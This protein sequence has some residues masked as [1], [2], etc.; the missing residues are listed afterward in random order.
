MKPY[1]I[2]SARL[3]FFGVVD[4]CMVCTAALLNNVKVIFTPPFKSIYNTQY[5]YYIHVYNNQ[6][7]QCSKTKIKLIQI[8]FHVRFYL[9]VQLMLL[10]YN[11]QLRKYYISLNKY[12]YII[13]CSSGLQLSATLSAIFYCPV[14]CQ[15]KYSCSSLY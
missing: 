2:Y 15:K 7:V 5:I 14:N 12:V 1:H 13:E 11:G 3:D 4:G 6:Y 9:S 10:E 8:M